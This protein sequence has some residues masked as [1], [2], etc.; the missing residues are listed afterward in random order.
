MFKKWFVFAVLA[1]MP[2]AALANTPSN[3]AFPASRSG[4]S[5]HN[6]KAANVNGN[7]YTIKVTQKGHVLADDTIA[8]PT[9]FATPIESGS[10]VSYV[11]SSRTNKAGVTE[12][13]SGVYKTGEDFILT[14]SEKNVNLVEFSGTVRDFVKMD[15]G[16]SHTNIPVINTQ[17]FRQTLYLPKGKTMVINSWSKVDGAMTVSITHE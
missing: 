11:E 1:G 7:M 8:A 2:F 9:G 5:V 13:T 6:A 10:Q 3:E 16:L 15:H 12:I 17:T 4:V 14:P